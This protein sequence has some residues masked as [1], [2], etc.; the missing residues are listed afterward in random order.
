[1]I[2]AQNWNF[3]VFLTS[4]EMKK[5]RIR[6]QMKTGFYKDLINLKINI[7]MI[8]KERAKHVIPNLLYQDRARYPKTE[9]I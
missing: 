2:K 4:F 8:K 9:A 6:T 3:Q 7:I 5:A 1:M